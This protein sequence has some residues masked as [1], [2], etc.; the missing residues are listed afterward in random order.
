MSRSITIDTKIGIEEMAK[1]TG[2]PM[3]VTQGISSWP[4]H[5]VLIFVKHAL[6]V[7]FSAILTAALKR[8]KK[9]VKMVAFKHILLNTENPI[10]ITGY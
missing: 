7:R 1:E 8:N 4:F 3:R 5:I 6:I 9:D 2:L 10:L